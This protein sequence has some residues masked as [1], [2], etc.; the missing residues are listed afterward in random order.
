[1]DPLI[2][3]IIM[4][5]GNFAPRGW[6]L[7]EGQLVAIS[8][9]TALFSLLGTTFGGD[10]RTT[11]G[12]PDM[13]GRTPIGAGNGPGLSDRRLGQ[14]G[15]TESNVLNVTQIPSHNHSA[16]GRLKVFNGAASDPSPKNNFPGTA[17]ARDISTGATVQVSDW[18][19]NANDYAAANGV[20]ITVNNTG[21]NQSVN[22]ME[23]WLAVNYI[24][25]LFGIYPSRS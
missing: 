20:E 18:S 9:N 1:M 2:A 22:N 13:R 6:A 7:C 8:S 16:A 21:G 11:F 10:G 25:A 3:T 12:L 17:S 15:G 19:S 23:P 14:K 24:I 5:G 4:F